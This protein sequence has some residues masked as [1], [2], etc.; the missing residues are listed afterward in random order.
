LTDRRK[1]AI[2]GGW[3]PLWDDCF[4]ERNEAVAP[5]QVKA[6][7]TSMM[8]YLAVAMGATE[9]DAHVLGTG[10]TPANYDTGRVRVLSA[11]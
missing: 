2:T 11:A 6:A 4:A 7:Y 9:V 5:E 1:A 10:R 8:A 3:D